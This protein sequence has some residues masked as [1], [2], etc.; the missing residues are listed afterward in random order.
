MK[1]GARNATEVEVRL[2]PFQS[3]FIVFGTAADRP[4]ATRTRPRTTGKP[5][6]LDGPWTLRL[7]AAGPAIAIDRLRS[8]TEVPEGA[9]YSGWATYETSFTLPPPGSGLD[10]EIDLG[11]VHETAEVW[12]NGRALGA[13]W[14]RPRRLPCGTALVA[15]RN[16][17]RIEVANLWIHAMVERP[18]PAEWAVL[19]ETVGIRWGRYGERKPDALPP[20]GLLG[21]VRLL[22]FPRG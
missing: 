8:W 21:P 17:L 4:R 11:H 9:A 5:V 7:G 18:A 12:L 14:K 19:E 10:W 2:D 16:E 13:A 20:A 3:C 1:S 6:P 15:G 22:P